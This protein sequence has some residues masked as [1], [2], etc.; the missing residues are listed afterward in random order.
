MNKI[1]TVTDKDGHGLQLGD[2]VE[3][4]KV[5]M[6][7]YGNV[8]DIDGRLDSEQIE[9]EGIHENKTE[10]VSG[11]DVVWRSKTEGAKKVAF[12]RGDSV[13]IVADYPADTI[14]GDLKARGVVGVVTDPSGYDPDYP[15]SEGPLMLDE[16]EKWSEV[17]FG[18]TEIMVPNKH[19][20]KVAMK[21]NAAVDSDGQELQVGD[22][23][24]VTTY[25]ALENTVEA[26]VIRVSPNQI[27]IRWYQDGMRY[28]TNEFTDGR[29]TI[30]KISSVK[31]A[32]SGQ[33]PVYY[34]EACKHRIEMNPD[35]TVCPACEA[36]I[37][38]WAFEE[39]G[40]EKKGN[41]KKKAEIED[42]IGEPVT[43][44]DKVIDVEGDEEGTV[45]EIFGLEAFIEWASGR[46]EWATGDMLVRA[47]KKSADEPVMT[48]KAEGVMS[49]GAYISSTEKAKETSQ[50]Q[51]GYLTG[52]ILK[53]EPFA[54]QFLERVKQEVGSI[55]EE[56]AEVLEW[57][58][59][60]TGL[61]LLRDNGLVRSASKKEAFYF[62]D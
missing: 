13:R 30:K 32:E 7:W 35:L 42:S 45:L 3:V 8:V 16:D 11:K 6:W 17:D 57:Y 29:K 27:Q 62:E 15:G 23:V 52:M 21:K 19:L 46:Q 51:F 10:W 61:S 39:A 47:M 24:S 1:A 53:E 36:T 54:S 12:N 31:K 2:T 4:Q 55:T 20:E 18:G 59:F 33:V 34:C 58:N 60:H 41:V 56:D 5:P 14:A 37:P 25:G 48:E 9:V 26:E 49:I 28:T 38:E 22:R 40:M 50:K 44:G 43:E